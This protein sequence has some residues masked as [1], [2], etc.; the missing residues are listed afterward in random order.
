MRIEGADRKK[1]RLLEKIQK[2]ENKS[3]LFADYAIVALVDKWIIVIK[4]QIYRQ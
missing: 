4:K 2:T 1:M 3:I